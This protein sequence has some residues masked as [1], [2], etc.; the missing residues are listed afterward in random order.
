MKEQNEDC[1]NGQI[2]CYDG[3]GEPSSY[4][5]QYELIEEL[6]KEVDGLK[7]ELSDCEDVID[8]QK[9]RIEELEKAIAWL[10]KYDVPFHIFATKH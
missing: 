7:R 4:Q 8:D 5:C 9:R 6:E 10:L 3:F 2:P 1:K